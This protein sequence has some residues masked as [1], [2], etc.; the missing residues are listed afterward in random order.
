[1]FASS[2][3]SS[4]AS[5]YVSDFV[6]G[7]MAF[8]LR[9]LQS[10]F[11][12]AVGRQTA[13]SLLFCFLIFVLIFVSCLLTCNSSNHLIL[14]A[15]ESNEPSSTSS[16]TCSSSVLSPICSQRPSAVVYW[17]CAETWSPSKAN[18]TALWQYAT[19]NTILTTYLIWLG[20]HQWLWLHLLGQ[21]QQQNWLRCWYD[22][23]V[24]VL[25]KFKREP[26]QTCSFDS[27]SAWWSC[28]CG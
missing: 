11:V 7:C 16:P 22:Q 8:C 12:I 19:T 3:I 6:E 15:I 24:F 28:T 14:Y 5:V 27:V 21:P 18:S 9:Q 26:L 4:R 10:S 13:C 20:L 1:M 23:S 2:T 25:E 17:I